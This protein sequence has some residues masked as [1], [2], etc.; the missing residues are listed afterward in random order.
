LVAGFHRIVGIVLAS[1]FLAEAAS[2]AVLLYRD[3][4]ER[5]VDP[6]AH[7]VSSCAHATS[8][9]DALATAT[10]ALGRPP[11]VIDWPSDALPDS[12][13]FSTTPTDPANAAQAFVDLCTG[14]VLAVRVAGST[15]SGFAFH[16]HDQLLLPGNL[17]YNSVAALG[18]SLL[19]FAL[20]GVVI[21]PGWRGARDALRL[22]FGA[23]PYAFAFDLHA[24]TGITSAAAL[25]VIAFT[26]LAMA[27]YNVSQAV[28]HAAM[29]DPDAPPTPMS[30]PPSSHSPHVADA[31]PIDRALTQLAQRLPSVRATEIGL[32]QNATD[33]LTIYIHLPGQANMYGT[34]VAY[35]DRYTGAV[36]SADPGWVLRASDRFMRA[37]LPLHMG[38]PYARDLRPLVLAAAAAMPVLVASGLIVRI[39]RWRAARRSG[40]RRR[41]RLGE[42]RRDRSRLA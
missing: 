31:R 40:D 10:R 39:T 30:R 22:R 5:L 23:R 15:L 16:V 34:G 38:T 29:R 2:G 24:L 21:W 4:L 17:G 9:D 20:S 36:L 18:A 12:L 11:G 35:A 6:S 7:R 3:V 41:E 13:R 27:N 26:G 8:I 42:A 28:V 32:P 14:R 33:P 19:L 25:L 37:M 1:F